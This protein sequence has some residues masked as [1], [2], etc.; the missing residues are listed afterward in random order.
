[1]TKK[2]PQKL[3]HRIDEFQDE[4]DA[5][6][7]K[8]IT[9]GSYAGFE[10][11]Y[12]HVTFK[13]G[14]TTYIYGRPF[15]GKSEYWFEILM[16]L[17]ELYGWKHFIF[18]PETGNKTEIAAELISKAARK[19]FYKEFKGAMTQNE[20]YRHRA[21]VSEHF[22]ILDAEDKSISLDD[23]YDQV[24]ACESYY[25]L[26][27][28]STLADPFN[29]L[30]Y[31]LQGKPRDIF[32]SEQLSKA[33]NNAQKFNRHN[34][35]ITHV[36]HQMPVKGVDVNGKEVYYFPMPTTSDIADGENWFRKAMNLIAVWR[37][38]HNVTDPSTGKPYETNEV[39]I[40]IQKYKPKYTGKLGIVKQYFDIHKNRYY[41]IIDGVKRYAD[42]QG[43]FE[44]PL[45]QD[46]M[47][48]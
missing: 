25:D 6:F 17:S 9:K 14:Q 16:N 39:H 26:K 44:S 32:L 18:S 42:K 10:Q 28:N 12:Q 43:S 41:E 1:M 7:E 29:E 19:P 30:Q 46:E 24:A 15:S 21:F 3:F 36:K 22:Y 45:T 11:L 20:L 47:P 38:P 33:R 5:L 48:F 31:D 35:L 8:G 13:P 34:A 4:I 37:P 27:I 23:F 40:N 2:P